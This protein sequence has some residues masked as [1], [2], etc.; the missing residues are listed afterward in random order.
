MSE[1][2]LSIPSKSNGVSSNE[3]SEIIT[4]FR[5]NLDKSKNM[6]N[7]LRDIP[8]IGHDAWKIQYGKTFEI[9]SFLWK[10]QQKHR[11]ILTENGNLRR[12][13]IGEIA[14]RIGQLYYQYYGRTSELIY[15]EESFNFYHNLRL[16][17]YYKNVENEPSPNLMVK[18]LRFYARYLLVILQMGKLQLL[19][20]VM[21]ELF[22]FV[23]QFSS[24]Y[25]EE[26]Q[27]EWALVC[28]ELQS[29]NQKLT[30]VKI[31]GTAT[32]KQGTVVHLDPKLRLT[33]DCIPDITEHLPVRMNIG[34]VVIM[35]NSI[36][37]V[38]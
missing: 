20:E 31:I 12:Y 5:E 30:F 14:S 36:G 34:R 18:K 24:I 6:F 29:F 17:N 32:T 33:H 15:L 2:E 27:E 22:H 23:A 16:R 19:L 26:D 8:P 37:Q 9:H 38:S 4:F 3:I 1:D 10:C 25:A 7:A 28:S 13:E 21:K 11:T 35:G